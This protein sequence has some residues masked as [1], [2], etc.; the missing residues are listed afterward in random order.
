MLTTPL[1]YPKKI[2]EILYYHKKQGTIRQNNLYNMLSTE[3][4]KKHGFLAT[5]VENNKI[6]DY[7]E[8]K[9]LFIGFIATTPRRNGYGQKII[10]FAKNLAKKEDC[11]GHIQL[12][13][14]GSFT[15]DDIPHLF[16]RKNG[17]STLDKKLDKKMDKFIKSGKVAT[18]KDFSNMPMYYP[19]PDKYPIPEGYKP[20]IFSRIK[21]F[22][23][24]I[25]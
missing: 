11:N 14:D 23:R 7:Y 20:N 12:Y 22:F 15:Q 24:N 8:G 9:L 5:W 18:H 17:F 19:A 16:Y 3:T 4:G 21:D 25:F 10:D 2:P 13:A 1:K 6:K